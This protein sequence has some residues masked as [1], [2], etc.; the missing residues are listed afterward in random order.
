M[1]HTLDGTELKVGDIVLIEAKVKEIQTTEDYCNLSL[2]TSHA[3]YP[4]EHKTALTLNA[5]QVRKK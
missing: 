5:G 2:E 3:M 1:P 4:G